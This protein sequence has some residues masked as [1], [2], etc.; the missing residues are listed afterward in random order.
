VITGRLPMEDGR[1]YLPNYHNLSHIKDGKIVSGR[2]CLD[3]VHVNDIFGL[4]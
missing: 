4:K 1:D 2:E 3:A